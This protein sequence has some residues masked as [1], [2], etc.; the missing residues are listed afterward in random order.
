M[1]LRTRGRRASFRKSGTPKLRMT[2][3]MD[4]LVVLLLFLLKSFVVEGEVMTPAAGVAL[5]ESTSPEL[6][7][8]TL[9]VSISG[10]SIVVGDKTVARVATV[11]GESELLIPGLAATLSLSSQHTADIRERTGEDLSAPLTATIQGDKATPFRVIEKVMYTLSQGG[12]ENI[13][14]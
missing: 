12:Y 5:P 14:L 3:M 2:S 10:E 7:E 8:A 13:S 6:P 4:I 1:R 11:E 9:V